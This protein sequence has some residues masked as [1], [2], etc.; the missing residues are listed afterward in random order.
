MK[1]KTNIKSIPTLLSCLKR[2]YPVG[3][4]RDIDSF[5]KAKNYLNQFD[6]IV[7]SAQF[8][9]TL[10][11]LDAM[12][13]NILNKDVIKRFKSMDFINIYHELLVGKVFNENGFSITH[14]PKINNQTPDWMISKNNKECIIEVFT[15]N[16]YYDL[17]KE[18][19]QLTIFSAKL[20]KL[21]YSFTVSIN[22]SRF[23]KSLNSIQKINN[24]I[25]E[26]IN[27]I[28]RKTSNELPVLS[29]SCGIDLTFRYSSNKNN[30]FIKGSAKMLKGGVYTYR[31][32]KAIQ[33]K[34][35]K[36][37]Q[38]INDN[39]LP[40][41]ICC[42]TENF[43]RMNTEN[44]NTII[45]GN[46]S[47]SGVLTINRCEEVSG[48]LILKN[49]YYHNVINFEYVANPYSMNPYSITLKNK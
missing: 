34:Y 3:H 24:A 41:I 6:L 13:I 22:N 16:K 40:F 38:L 21:K 27:H 4:F 31:I 37:K 42:T 18:S 19:K 14:N 2:I 11:K 46:K 28:D 45:F 29:L 36:Y 30:I 15:S 10:L 25:N 26:V 5:E 8:Y 23:D 9:D 7:R 20:Q 32:V 47:N 17:V 43:N 48:F 33:E 44:F 35:N 12:K 1:K 49:N 39:K